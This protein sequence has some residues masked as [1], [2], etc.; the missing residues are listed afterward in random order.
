MGRRSLVLGVSLG[1]VLLATSLAGAPGSARAPGGPPTAA[2]AAARTPALRTRHP[3]VYLDA[4]NL[5]RLQ[6]LLASGDPAAVRFRHLVDGAVG[7]DDVYE[8]RAWYS[9]L[10]GALTGRRSYCTDAVGRVQ[11][12]VGKEERRIAAGKV[13]LIAGDSY[14]EVGPRVAEIALTIDWCHGAVTTARRTDW[15]AFADQ[16]VWNVWHH[17]HARWGDHVVKWT[18]WSVDNPSDNYYYSFL[19]ATELLGLA[20]LGENPMAQQWLDKFT[21]KIHDQLVPTFDAQLHGGGSREGTGYG[22]A[23][24]TLWWLYD[25]WQASTGESIA[26]LTTH[27]R[28]SMAYLMHA[29]LPTL[30]RIA[31][32]GD[33]SRDSTAALFDYHRE[34]GLALAQLFPDD[35]LT[36]NLRSWLATNSVPRMTQP[37]EYVWDLLYGGGPVTVAPPQPLR[38]TYFADGTGHLFARSGWTTDATWLQFSMGAHT[39]S[40]AHQDQ[41]SFM[42]F[43]DGWLAY[44]PGV[45]SASGLK[46]D[47][48]AHNLVEIT[49]GGDELQQYDGSTDVEAFADN[50]TFTYAAADATGLYADP[51]GNQPADLVQREIVYLKPGVLVVHDRVHAEAGTAYHWLLSSPFEPTVAGSTASFDGGRLVDRAIE[52]GGAVASVTDLTTVGE[53][54]AGGYRLAWTVPGGDQV[55]FLHVLSVDGAVTSAV[56][57]PQG[58]QDG[59]TIGLAS[60][61]TATVRFERDDV[62]GTL[63]LSDGSYDAPL[64]TGVQQLPL[65]AP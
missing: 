48:D 40:H 52:P 6:S 12:L 64:P 31:P 39:E 47:T 34:Y 15:I 22:N 9:A 29:T 16:A 59:V 19:E 21:S 11:R 17:N 54:Y 50:D 57:D 25:V 62:G 38:T 58:S 14:L 41:L 28:L 3:L 2:R 5:A 7:G 13:P 32:I 33:Q 43:D 53:D 10:M 18:G 26:D 46:Q 60:G 30:D 45:E 63:A 55:D 49:E 65:F 35:P 61:V 23:M 37:F 56:A 24:R 20:T 8:Y 36:E 42:L 27:A 1:A 44:D 51:Y 4:D